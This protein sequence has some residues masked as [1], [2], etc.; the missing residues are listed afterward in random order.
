[1]PRFLDISSHLPAHFKLGESAPQL[2]DYFPAN[3]VTSPRA[4]NTAPVI[5]ASVF[6][7][8]PKD[9]N[10]ELCPS[11][12]VGCNPSN[13]AESHCRKLGNRVGIDVSK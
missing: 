10:P 2:T 5:E 1:M 9:F 12:T 4:N 7:D 8:F 3:G 6:P 13:C 11:K